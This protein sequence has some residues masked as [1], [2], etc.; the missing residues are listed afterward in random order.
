MTSRASNSTFNLTSN[1]FRRAETDNSITASLSN[2]RGGGNN[3]FQ[4]GY[5]RQRFSAAR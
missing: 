4:L 3:E 2:M 5:I 1:Q